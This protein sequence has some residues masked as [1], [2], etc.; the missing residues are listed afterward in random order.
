MPEL[1]EVETVVRGL[2]QA[3]L[4]EKIAHV[5]IHRHDLR[6]PIPPD[7]G[8]RLTG[9]RLE[10]LGRRAKYVCANLSN[11]DSL[12]IHLGMSGRLVIDD[13]DT[14]KHEHVR[15]RFQS[16]R[17]L[18]FVDPRRFGYIDIC[19]TSA[20]PDYH[21]FAHLGLEPLSDAFTG[22]WLHTSTRQRKRPI[23]SHI[24]DQ[25]VVV[26]VGNIYA[27]EALFQSGI[28]P[29]LEASRLR[30]HQSEQLAL[31]IRETLHRAIEAGGSSL[32]D[33]VQSD[34]ELGYFQHQFKVYGREGEPCSVCGKALENIRIS[35]RSTFFCPTCQKAPRTQ[36]IPRK[37][38]SEAR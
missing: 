28:H 16:G 13:P 20:L 2:R 30:P 12:L 17:S 1:P 34:G 31:A 33:Y 18:S 6:F 8:Q 7:L 27:C 14:Q 11:D 10:S 3:L 38:R 29:M 37:R 35:N 32:R 5:A 19:P 24:M 26:G 22:D 4:H 21:R 36:V 25:E 23:K 9:Q 15:L